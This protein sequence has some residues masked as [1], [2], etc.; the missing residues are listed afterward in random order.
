MNNTICRPA[1]IEEIAVYNKVNEL[2]SDRAFE[3]LLEEDPFDLLE[4]NIVNEELRVLLEEDGITIEE[5]CIF[6]FI[7]EE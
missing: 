3:L 5:A 6:A 2:I 7:D 4:D 1:T